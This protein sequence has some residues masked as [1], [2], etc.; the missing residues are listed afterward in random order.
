MG[1]VALGLL[2]R[3]EMVETRWPG[4]FERWLFVLP[5]CIALVA[6][7]IDHL[8]NLADPNFDLAFDR[9]N[10]RLSTLR[11]DRLVHGSIGRARSA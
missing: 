6:T 4:F 1:L 8:R 3:P 7:S 10:R 9:S 5:Y 11:I 2:A